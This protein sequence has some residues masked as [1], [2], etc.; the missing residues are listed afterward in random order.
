M[1][2]P[3]APE[4]MESLLSELFEAEQPF[5]CP[6]GRPIILRLSDTDLEV[7]FKRR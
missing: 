1:H 6:H 2:D 5:A 7:R 3:L 4:A